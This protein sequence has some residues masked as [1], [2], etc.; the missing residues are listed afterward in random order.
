MP[1]LT[2]ITSDISFKRNDISIPMKDKEDMIPISEYNRFI[3]KAEKELHDR[4]DELIRIQKLIH[5]LKSKVKQ[6]KEENS[7]ESKTCQDI[8]NQINLLEQLRRRSSLFLVQVN[9][10]L[11]YIEPKSST[12]QKEGINEMKNNADDKIHDISLYKK[13][14]VSHNKKENIENPYQCDSHLIKNNNDNN[15]NDNNNKRITNMEAKVETKLTLRRKPKRRIKPK[16]VSHTSNNNEK[17]NKRVSVTVTNTPV[18]QKVIQKFKETK[19]KVNSHE[20][21]FSPPYH[22]NKNYITYEF[23]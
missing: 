22:G 21:D 20:S 4:L 3:G 23:Q 11:N 9:R 17:I 8:I 2:K 15:N 13:A 7:L 16:P 10:S 18:I 5:I 6:L 1:K 14:E 12:K 19:I